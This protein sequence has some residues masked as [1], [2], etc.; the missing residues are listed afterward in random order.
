MITR[1]RMTQSAHEH[2]ELTRHMALNFSK[3]ALT[4]IKDSMAAFSKSLLKDRI[5]RQLWP[6]ECEKHSATYDDFQMVA[7]H[8]TRILA[9]MDKAQRD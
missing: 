4:E 7:Y 9:A 6:S 3:S 2:A 5:D 1:D 8:L